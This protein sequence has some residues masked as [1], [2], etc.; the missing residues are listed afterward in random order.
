MIIQIQKLHE[1]TNVIPFEHTA[2]SLEMET[3]EEYKGVTFPEP[4]DIQADIQKVNHQYFVNIDVQTKVHMICD[5]CLD[6]F[7]KFL[8]DRFRIIY[9]LESLP[10]DVD[11]TEEDYRTLATESTDIDVSADIREALLLMIPMKILCTENCNGL[12]P[13]CGAH[14]NKKDCDCPKETIDPRWEAL[15]KLKSS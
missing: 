8:S 15:Q 12:C 1:G 2:A 5:C 11:E 10:T 4:I 9:A 13:S 3:L 7:E 6:P 14:L